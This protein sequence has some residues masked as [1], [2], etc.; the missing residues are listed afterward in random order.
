MKV[1]A[2]CSKEYIQLKAPRLIERNSPSYMKIQNHVCKEH[3]SY[4]S[5]IGHFTNRINKQF[6]ICKKVLFSSE[7]VIDLSKEEN[8][9]DTLYKQ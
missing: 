2:I 8:H 7:V 5:V 4:Q 6:I 3:I 9:I 1:I